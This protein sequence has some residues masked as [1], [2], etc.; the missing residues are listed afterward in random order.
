MV[1]TPEYN[2][3]V[4]M[5]QRCRNPKQKWYHKYGGRG[6]TI[7]EEWETFDNFIKDMGKRPTPKH[8]IDRIDNDGNYEPKNCRWATQ[9]QQVLNMGLRK[10]NKLGLKGIVYDTDRKKYR[11]NLWLK[12]KQKFIGRFVEKEDAIKAR[13]DAVTKYYM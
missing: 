6:I 12:G 13:A 9:H 7:C 2:A 8:S 11:V 3:W 1:R 10:D 4:N 5:R